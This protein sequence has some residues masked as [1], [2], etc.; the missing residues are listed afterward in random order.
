MTT[1]FET[2]D[3]YIAAFPEHVQV[4][5]QQMRATIRAAAPEAK[6]AIKYGMP[7]FVLHG[8]LVYFAGFKNHIGFYATPNGNEAFASQLADYKQWKGSIQFPLSKPLPLDL[9]TR[10]TQFRKAENEQKAVI[11]RNL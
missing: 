6:E 9:V 8:N 3:D 10:M 7:T 1:Q 2:I 11:K 5:L 4:L